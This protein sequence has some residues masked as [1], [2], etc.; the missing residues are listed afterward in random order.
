MQNM[1]KRESLEQYPHRCRDG[2]A[3]GF[4]ESGLTLVKWVSAAKD[5]PSCAPGDSFH[6]RTPR[7]PAQ[8]RHFRR[9]L[10]LSARVPFPQPRRVRHE[11]RF[12]KV[13]R[14]GGCL[15]PQSYNGVT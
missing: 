2:V 10:G 7:L 3:R 6:R 5:L 15:S 4:P 11:G 1:R 9:L 12:R 14:L 8:G 13:P